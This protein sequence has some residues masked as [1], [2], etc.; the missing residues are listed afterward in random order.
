MMAG[1]GLPLSEQ[2]H[3]NRQRSVAGL[4]AASAATVSRFNQRKGNLNG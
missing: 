2:Y 1:A 3:Q 4:F